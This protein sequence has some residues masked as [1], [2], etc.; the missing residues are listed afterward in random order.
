KINIAGAYELLKGEK[1]QTVEAD[2]NSSNN[3]IESAVIPMTVTTSVIPSN[4][5]EMATQGTTVT[6]PTAATLEL[7]IAPSNASENVSSTGLIQNNQANNNI[8][9][10]NVVPS[11]RSNL[12]YVLGTLGYDFGTEAR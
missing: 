2:N 5:T 12:V 10:N 4:T 6:T 3:I 7:V 9:L 8:V 1:L 11:Q